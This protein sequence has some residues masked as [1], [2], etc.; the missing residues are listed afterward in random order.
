MGLAKNARLNALTGAHPAHAAARF[1]EVGEK[2]RRFPR[3]EYAA[4]SRDRGRRV[5]ARIEHA[6]HGASLCYIVSS[7]PGEPQAFYG[8]LSCARRDMGNCTRQNQPGLSVDRTSCRQW[9]ANQFRL[10]LASL[11]YT[12]LE[13]TRRV[14]L[15]DRRQSAGV[16]GYLG[17]DFPLNQP[18]GFNA[19]SDHPR[20]RAALSPGARGLRFEAYTAP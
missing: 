16:A 10:L 5:I 12:L 19:G 7:L 14:G 2:V 13:T 6:R 11:A 18:S 4:R 1:A 8:R 17:A 3:L 15:N 9:W 20:F